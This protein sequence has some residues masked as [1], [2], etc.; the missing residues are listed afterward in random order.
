[1]STT[2]QLRDLV[3]NETLANRLEELSNAV[4]HGREAVSREFTMRV[5]ADPDRDADLVLSEAARRIRSLSAQA[6]PL[7][8]ATTD[9][10]QR[11]AAALADKLATA[12]AKY[13]YTNEWADPSWMDEC[14]HR[15]LE[16]V[17]KGDPRDVAAYCAFLW[18]HDE[19]TASAPPLPRAIVPVLAELERATRKFPTW[20][21]DPVH[22]AAVLQEEAG[23]V[24][25]AVLQAVYEP[26]KSGPAD[27]REEVVQTAAMCLRFLMSMER[28]AWEPSAQHE[29]G[30]AA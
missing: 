1:M 3:P 2:P 21:T 11:F 29:Q 13:G 9:L 4:T 5:P 22:A 26:H 15:L 12:E 7:H 18:H 30:R 19:R 10:V 14:R 23:E 24:S 20:P 8:P 27:V 17:A 25:K 16:H 28:Y 6:S